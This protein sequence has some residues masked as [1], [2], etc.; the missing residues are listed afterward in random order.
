MASS[1]GPPVPVP[2]RRSLELVGGL[3]SYTMAASAY[4]PA[5]LWSACLFLYSVLFCRSRRL[6]FATRAFGRAPLL[7]TFL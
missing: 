3:P 6:E 1:A 2:G 4:L 5:C 7:V